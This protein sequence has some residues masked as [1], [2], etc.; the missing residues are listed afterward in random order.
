MTAVSLDDLGATGA[1]A[2]ALIDAV[3]LLHDM[4]QVDPASAPLASWAMVLTLRAG[5]DGH[6]CLDLADMASLLPESVAGGIDVAAV[7]AELVAVTA[8]VDSSGADEHRP[9]IPFV[10]VDDRL[11]VARARAEERAVAAALVR[12]GA[13]HLSVVLGGPGTGKTT[14]IAGDLV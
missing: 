6:S 7:R 4:A 8:L 13:A 10:L 3:R 12:D 14:R 9:G 2:P 1:V 5:E 11:Y